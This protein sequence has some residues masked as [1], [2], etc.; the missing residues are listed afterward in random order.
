M[1]TGA[2]PSAGPRRHTEGA[3]HG[4]L[5]GRVAIVTGASAGIG[6]ATARELAR[7]G[8]RVVLVARRAD[9]LD[10]QVA[11]I[12]QAGG[13]A[14]AVPTDVSDAAQV[15]ALVRRTLDTFGRID[16]LVNNVGG[17]A[18]APLTLGPAE[19]ARMVDTNLTGAILLTQ[20][21]LPGMVERHHGAII[22]VAAVTGA[23]ALD[24]LYSATKFGLRGFTLSLRR[25]VA[26]SGVAVSVVSPGYIQT[27]PTRRPNFFVPGPGTVARRIA[28]L[29]VRP[30]RE[31]FI[32]R[33]YRAAVWVEH[34][35]PWVWDL[36]AQSRAMRR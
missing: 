5:G 23:V 22:A 9:R 14:L 16:I 1:G 8:A 2:D 26:G 10:V 29:V 32:P 24:P 34:T 35:L 3:G 12:T 6:A 27:D 15:A 33:A 19:I 13:F 25:Q 17:G 11:A 4:P 36:V 31:V 28:D 20:A 30:R 21:V 7:R 18:F